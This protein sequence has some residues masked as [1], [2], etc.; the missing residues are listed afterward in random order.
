MAKYMFTGSFTADGARGIL[1]EGGTARRAAVEKL[2]ATAGGTL[3]S[4]YFAFGSDDFFIVGDLPDD[5]SA[6]AAAL[7]TSASG[8]VRT[9]TVVLLTPEEVDEAARKT[10]AYRAPGA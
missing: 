8:A 2:F 1:A 10:P 9:R 5:A 6:A 4:Y 7:T 3:E